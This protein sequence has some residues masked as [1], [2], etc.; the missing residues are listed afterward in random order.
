MSLLRIHKVFPAISFV[1]I[2]FLSFVALA[3]D[4]ISQ[5]VIEGN[6][7]IESSAIE[8]VL[9]NKKGFLLSKTQ[10]ANDIQE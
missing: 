10:I 3:S 9:K 7:Q 4:E 8:N 6:Q 5:I 1:F 2:A